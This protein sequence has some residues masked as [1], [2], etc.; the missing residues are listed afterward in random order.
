MEKREESNTAV[1]FCSFMV[2]EMEG[3]S[4]IITVKMTKKILYFLPPKNW[5]CRM[6]LLGNG[7]F[8]FAIDCLA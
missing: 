1:E 7:L 5:I 8:L 4:I 2:K 6:R 3:R